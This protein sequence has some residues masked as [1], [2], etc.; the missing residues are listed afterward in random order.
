MVVIVERPGA[1]T[2][3]QDLGRPGHAHL[4]VPTAGAA[5]LAAHRL[6]N[7]LVG[8]AAHA[9]TLETTLTGVTLRLTCQAWAA[10]TGAVAPVT[11][12][13][14]PVS[15]GLPVLVRAGQTLDVGQATHGLRSYVSLSGGIDVSPVL[16]SRS[17]D[18]LAGIGPS[19]LTVGQELTLG[20]P[21]RPSA[22]LD[23]APWPVPRDEPVLAVTAGPR[24]DWF[25]PDAMTCLLS[26][27]WTVTPDSNRIGIRLAGPALPRAYHGE[28]PSEGTV[29]GAVQVPPDGQPLIFLNDHPSTV[30][31]PVIATVSPTSLNACA[32]VRPGQSVR[33]TRCRSAGPGKA[34]A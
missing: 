7:R 30:G 5:D 34:M 10:V 28:L 11:V 26:E 19:P 3:I 22:C 18:I 21:G 33:F 27:R 23:F 25:T 13:G 4:A 17:R 1:L 29:T 14:R 31:Y 6:A 2:T 9:A 12:D 16:G 24:A 8:N 15:W 32:Q 20:P